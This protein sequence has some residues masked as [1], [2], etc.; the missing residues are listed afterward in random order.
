MPLELKYFVLNPGGKKRAYARASRDALRA[1]SKA[2]QAE[3]PILASQLKDW[4][5]REEIKAHEEKT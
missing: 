1:Y 2:I 5:D 4:A 3:D